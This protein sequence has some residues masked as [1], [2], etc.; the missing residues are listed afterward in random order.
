M[1]LRWSS[2]LAVLVCLC[3]SALAQELGTPP[4]EEEVGAHEAP[5][6]HV[7]EQ[8]VRTGIEASD[9]V[10]GP[11]AEVF[12][13]VL[14]RVELIDGQS[15]VG[16]LRSRDA[17]G[18]TLEIGDGPRIYL[19]RS[20]IAVVTEEVEVPSPDTVARPPRP[21]TYFFSPSAMLLREGEGSFAQLELLFSELSYGIT[22][23]LNFSVSSAVPLWFIGGG[24]GFNVGASVKAG[25]SVNEYV[26]LAGGIYGFFAPVLLSG[27]FGVAFGSV[28]LGTPQQNLTLS[29]GVPVLTSDAYQGPVINLSGLMQ[30]SRMVAVVSE[31]WSFPSPSGPFAAWLWAGGTRLDLSPFSVD[32]GIVVLGVDRDILPLPIPWLSAAYTFG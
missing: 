15:L 32:V 20:T 4:H 31:L 25:G 30:V 1:S 24:G 23:N 29:V 2:V 21:H 9:V 11:A 27:T 17:H 16:R 26:H 10:S 12:S 5:D 14:H 28:T 7:D 8:A 13:P 6:V 3:G 19:S 18:V 22:D